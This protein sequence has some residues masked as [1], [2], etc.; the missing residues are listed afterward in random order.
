MGGYII[1]TVNMAVVRTLNNSVS[2]ITVWVIGG[3]CK[4][5]CCDLEEVM[6]EDSVSEVNK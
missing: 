1:V 6:T 5:Y 3:W 2:S 4:E